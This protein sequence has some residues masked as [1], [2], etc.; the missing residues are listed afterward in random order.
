MELSPTNTVQQPQVHPQLKS[1]SSLN[2]ISRLE[3]FRS[4]DTPFLYY[5]D[6]WSVLLPTRSHRLRS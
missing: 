6:A 3:S 5:S 1:I 4:L 2:S